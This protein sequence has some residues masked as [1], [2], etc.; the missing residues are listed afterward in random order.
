MRWEDWEAQD[1]LA[2]RRLA[3]NFHNDDPT[4]PTPPPTEGEGVREAALFTAV[5]VVIGAVVLVWVVVQVARHWVGAAQ[6]VSATTVLTWFCLASD[7]ALGTAC[8]WV[9][10]WFR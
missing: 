5:A 7:R 6:L 9:R 10:G 2:V 3:A 8:S 4:N 1:K